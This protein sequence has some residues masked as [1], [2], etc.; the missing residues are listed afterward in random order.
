MAFGV[1]GPAAGAP[2]AIAFGFGTQGLA[3][4]IVEKAY[5]RRDEAKQQGGQSRVEAASPSGPRRRSSA[6]RF[7]RDE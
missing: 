7:R 1:P 2:S 5:E 6:R 3:R 4:Y